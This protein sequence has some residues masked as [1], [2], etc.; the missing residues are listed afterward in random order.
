MGSS[1][2]DDI[3][4]DADDELFEVFGTKGG[5]LYEAKDGGPSETVGAVILENV[6]SPNGE[7]FVVV[8]LAVD[9]RV[10]EVPNPQRG[11]LVTVN[12]RRYALSELLG[13]DGK[14]N[15]YSL[16]PVD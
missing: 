14:I 9:L 6:G 11:D 13:T 1:E 4:D 7:T 5:A 10:S 8:A 12:C 16:Q 3:F 2:F 15:R